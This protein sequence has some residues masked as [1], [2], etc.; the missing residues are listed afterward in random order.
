M[1]ACIE[2]IALRRGLITPKQFEALARADKSSYGDYLKALVAANIRQTRLFQHP[3]A[4]DPAGE[5]SD[6]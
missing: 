5:P 1:I 4:Q 3:A 6:S 2:E